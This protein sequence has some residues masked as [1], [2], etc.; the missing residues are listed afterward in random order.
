MGLTHLWVRVARWGAFCQRCAANT[1]V[2]CR[3]LAEFRSLIKDDL[4]PSAVTLDRL[5]KANR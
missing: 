4:S 3:A 1:S 2:C 5:K